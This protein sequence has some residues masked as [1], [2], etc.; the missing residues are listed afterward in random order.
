[1]WALWSFLMTKPASHF[2]FLINS[3]PGKYVVFFCFFSCCLTITCLEISV[4]DCFFFFL[5]NHFPFVGVKRFL[6]VGQTWG[7]QLPLWL[8]LQSGLKSFNVYWRS[9]NFTVIIECEFKLLQ[10]HYFVWSVTDRAQFR[11]CFFWTWGYSHVYCGIIILYQWNRSDPLQTAAVVSFLYKQRDD[12]FSLFNNVW[13][14][15]EASG[16]AWKSR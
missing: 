15:S 13:P 16:N 9:D 12:F 5:G 1:M 6:F 8:C 4:H 10:S 11:L 7:W 14:L 3:P 2:I